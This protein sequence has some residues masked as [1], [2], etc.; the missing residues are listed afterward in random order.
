MPGALYDSFHVCLCDEVSAELLNTDV[1]KM[2]SLD[3][4]AVEKPSRV[5][6]SKEDDKAMAIIGKETVFVSDRYESGLRWK[7][8]N[9]RLPCSKSMALKR[10]HCLKQRMQK[11]PVLDAAVQETIRNCV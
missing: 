1:K 3:T 2:F 8:D 6:R 10:Y 7:A 11:D 4:I 5:L 9:I